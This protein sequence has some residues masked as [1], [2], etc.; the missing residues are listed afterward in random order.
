MSQNRLL[1][2]LFCFVFQPFRNIKPTLGFSGCTKTGF[3][4][5]LANDSH[6][7]NPALV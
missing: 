4:P 5:D 1:L 3:G 6:F 7:A 2:V